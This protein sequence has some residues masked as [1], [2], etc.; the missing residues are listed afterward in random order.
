MENGKW[1]KEKGKR[2]KK[3]RKEKKRREPIVDKLNLSNLV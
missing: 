3:K 2:E 1:K